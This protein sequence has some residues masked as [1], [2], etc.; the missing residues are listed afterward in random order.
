MV[1][2][3]KATGGNQPHRIAFSPDGSVLAVG[4]ADAAPVDLFDGHSLA[5]L[6]GPNVDGVRNG[7]LGIVIWSK[8]GKIFYAAGCYGRTVKLVLAWANAGRGERRCGQAANESGPCS[9]AGRRGSVP[10][11]KIRS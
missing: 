1:P 3:R 4:Y 9:F 5:P 11:R 2:P 10:L 6:P 7:T 8:D